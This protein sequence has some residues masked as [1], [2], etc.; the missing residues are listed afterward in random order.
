MAR[1]WVSG[2]RRG[3]RRHVP[4]SGGVVRESDNGE[5]AWVLLCVSRPLVASRRVTRR[6]R[7]ALLLPTSAMWAE[8]DG[9]SGRRWHRGLGRG[10]GG[11]DAEGRGREGKRR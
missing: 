9:V 10:H 8:G 3:V 2:V 7:G 11:A 5:G 6:Q 4:G 1:V